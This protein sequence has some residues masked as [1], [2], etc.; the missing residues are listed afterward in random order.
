MCV[1]ARPANLSN[2]II[3]A[4]EAKVTG[5][6]FHVLG[7]QNRAANKANGPNAMILPIPSAKPMSPNNIVDTSKCPNILKAYQTAV[8]RP[9]YRSMTKGMSRGIPKGVAQVFDSGMYT[10][11]LAANAM[12]IPEALGR[13]AAHKRPSISMELLEAYDRW[14][15]GW[16]IAVCC[17]QETAVEPD[18]IVW[19]YDPLV[20]DHLFLPT[21][22]AHDGGVPKVNHRI[23]LD[24]TFVFGSTINPNG[25]KVY[26]GEKPDLSDVNHILPNLVFGRHNDED[27]ETVY[28][29]GDHWMHVDKLS[30]Q[31]VGTVVKPPPGFTDKEGVEAN[32]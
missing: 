28:R 32:V 12:Q 6:Y 11:V 30:Q 18:P 8:A 26:F 5:V 19:A 22:D 14:Y 27:T 24:H 20:P 3:Y 15:Q 10:V 31:K 21:L 9:V 25:R 16:P 4:G 7:Y 17:F 29:N 13:V 1:T 2:T 23:K